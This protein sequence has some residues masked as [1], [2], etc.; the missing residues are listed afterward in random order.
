MLPQHQPTTSAARRRLLT[1]PPLPAPSPL[2]R[3]AFLR[4]LSLLLR[5]L[6][7]HTQAEGEAENGK[8]R[9]EDE[10]RHYEQMFIAS[11]SL[12]V[13]C[14]TSTEHGM[15]TWLSPFGIEEG[16][17]LESRMAMMSAAY[18]GVMCAGRILWAGLSGYVTST[19]PMLFLDVT[20]CALAC[21][22]LM[23]CTPGQAYFEQLLWLASVMLGL[24]VAS[25]LPC[26]YSLPPEVQVPMSP[27]A[28]A[29]LNAASTAGEM[30]MPFI[31][32]LAFGRNQ[33]WLFSALLAG[34]MAVA[35]SVSFAAWRMARIYGQRARRPVVESDL[36]P[37]KD[38][39]EGLNR[40]LPTA[41]EAS[42]Q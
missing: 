6:A 36:Y 9:S 17:L 42:Y 23:L 5:A 27:G 37:T 13:Y 32:G 22:V 16:G 26:V 12:V 10:Q 20:L 40:R 8:Q 19:W 34:C 31:I 28:I 3:F 30:S 1:K 33:Y 14:I 4:F 39:A 38:A 41:S 2:P 24:G 35:F 29:I 18:W 7:A 15:A 25:G 11:M 21:F